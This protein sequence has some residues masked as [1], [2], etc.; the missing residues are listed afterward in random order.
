MDRMPQKRSVLHRD[1]IQIKSD[2][3]PVGRLENF[4]KINI[5]PV[6]QITR[7]IINIKFQYFEKNILTNAYNLYCLI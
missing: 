6:P 1:L 7:L 2:N 5:L 3:P 4:F